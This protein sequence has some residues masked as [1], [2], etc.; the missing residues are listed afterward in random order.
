MKKR[1]VLGL[2]AAALLFSS[3]VNNE[4]KSDPACPV[5]SPIGGF[6]KTEQTVSIEASGS[7]AIYYTILNIT[8]I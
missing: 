2:A 5:F 7:T 1:M 3:C 4:P 6:Y 8:L